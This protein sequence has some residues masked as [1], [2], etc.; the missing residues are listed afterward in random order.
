MGYKEDLLAELDKTDQTLGWRE[1]KGLLSDQERA[2]IPL[3]QIAR[4]FLTVLA[5]I[6]EDLATIAN[7]NRWTY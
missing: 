4:P 3:L 7:S 2:I 5:D 1:D 6:S